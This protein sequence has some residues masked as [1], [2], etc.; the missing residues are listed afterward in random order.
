[1]KGATKALE[2]GEGLGAPF[3]WWEDLPFP[4]S[5]YFLWDI[6]LN[7]TECLVLPLGLSYLICRR[8]MAFQKVELGI[9]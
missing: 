8:L 9:K 6:F 3:F 7:A 2:V 1:M 4:V 5:C